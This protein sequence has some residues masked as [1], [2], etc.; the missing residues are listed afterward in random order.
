VAQA[1][2]P[3]KLTYDELNV[4]FISRFKAI[5]TETRVCMVKIEADAILDDWRL[6][7]AHKYSQGAEF[8]DS[9]L[10]SKSLL[11]L[12]STQAV[13]TEAKKQECDA[14]NGDQSGPAEQ[15]GLRP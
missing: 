6:E 7:Y 4:D 13:C 5:E 10:K 1:I 14:G 12:Q 11:E 9:T 3:K 8:V 2:S 15:P